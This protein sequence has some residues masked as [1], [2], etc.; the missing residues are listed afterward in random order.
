M[1][2]IPTEFIFLI[3]FIMGSITYYIAK[4]R[5]RKAYL[6]FWYGFFFGLLGVLFIYFLP[7]KKKKKEPQIPLP[8]PVPNKIW[9]YLS[10]DMIQ[11]GPISTPAL[12]QAQ[13]DGTVTATTYVW[14]PDLEDWKQLGTIQNELNNPLE[15]L[16][17]KTTS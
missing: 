4:K 13:K 14:N 17:P 10:E 7:S 15:E 12:K 6:W 8:D 5:E 3:S 9:Y 16:L 11:S 2:Q 1:Q